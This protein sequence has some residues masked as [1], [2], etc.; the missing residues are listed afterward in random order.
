MLDQSALSCTLF[1]D[2]MKEEL[3]VKL[4]VA[5]K[6]SSMQSSDAMLC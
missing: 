1:V 6:C 4:P 3:L 5:I 2:Q